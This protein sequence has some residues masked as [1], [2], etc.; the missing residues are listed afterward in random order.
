MKLLKQGKTKDVY[1]LNN[2][3]VLLKFKDTVTGDE[4]GS[5]DPGG[6]L[7]V[8]E[9]KGVGSSALNVTDYYFNILKKLG[10]PTHYVSSNL[11]NNEMVVKPAKMFGNG[12][13][14]IIRYKAF[15]S[16]IRRFGLYVT[17][18]TKLDDIFEITLKDDGRNDPPVTKEIITK[19]G[20][21]NEKQYEEAEQLVRKVCNI[22]KDDLTKKGLE[23]VDIKVEVGIVDGVVSLIDEISGGNMR[24]FKDGK[25]LDYLTLSNEILK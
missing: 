13:E 12:L 22:V 5:K 20:I 15:G 23:L 17:E 8:G 18:G 9:V 16:F 4:S 3:D 2:G 25:A 11:K 7:V 14:F 19:L 21:L 10:I 1:V 24:V 6:N